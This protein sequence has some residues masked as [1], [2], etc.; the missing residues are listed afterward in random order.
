MKTRTSISS[1]PVLAIVQSIRLT[2]WTATTPVTKKLGLNADGTIEKL[3]TAAQLYE[4][5]VAT[6]AVT[7]AELLYLLSAVRSTD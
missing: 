7:P 3:S 4:G 5:T 2:K 6:Q 1:N